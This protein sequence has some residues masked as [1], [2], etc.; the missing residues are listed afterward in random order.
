MFNISFLYFTHI[1]YQIFHKLNQ[2]SSKSGFTDFNGKSIPMNSSTINIRSFKNSLLM[3]LSA[4]PGP[5]QE[6]LI[7][8]DLFNILLG[9]TGNYIRTEVD[10][11][12]IDDTVSS[13]ILPIVAPILELSYNAM[14][15]SNFCFSFHSPSHGRVIQA[16]STALDSY[17][18]DLRQLVVALEKRF[19]EGGYLLSQLNFYLLPF[20]E[21]FS[22]LA[23]II[24]TVTEK[25]LFGGGL[26]NFLETKAA[27]HSGYLPMMTYIVNVL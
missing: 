20:V 13:Q 24:T 1:L 6:L 2:A 12:S 3:S 7:V 22:I 27:T 23:D 21:P 26:I 10:G 15:A 19:N 17:L 11:Y 9:C 14:K 4:Q 16:F 5:I 18:L 25:N 8:E